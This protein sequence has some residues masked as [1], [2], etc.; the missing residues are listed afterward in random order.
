[1]NGNFKWIEFL[2]KNNTLLI[3]N[4]KEFNQFKKF[5]QHLDML[6]ILGKNTEYY[7]WQYLAGINCKPTNY[8]IFEYDNYKGLT[9]GYTVQKSKDWYDKE[10]LTIKDLEIIQSNIKDKI[11][12]DRGR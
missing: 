1:M 5:L 11:L 7:N 3:N 6:S 8:I 2:S 9:F 4:E 12:N 10:P